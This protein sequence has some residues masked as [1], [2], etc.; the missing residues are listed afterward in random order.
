M[1]DPIDVVMKALKDRAEDR[2]SSNLSGK[3][4]H[5]AFRF[6]SI[7]PMAYPRKKPI[8][9]ARGTKMIWDMA[10]RQKNKR[11]TTSW[12]FWMTRINN[13]TTKTI[14]ATILGFMFVPLQ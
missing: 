13:N 7:R 12:V 4:V 9:T 11:K 10:I 2:A 3:R 8:N 14:R 6:L 1:K 5:S